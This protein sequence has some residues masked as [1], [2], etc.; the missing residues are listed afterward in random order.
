M[1]Q[2]Y[3][4]GFVILN[5]EVYVGDIVVVVL[6]VNVDGCL[7][8]VINIVVFFSCWM[9]VD[10]IVWLVLFVVNIVCLIFNVVCSIC[11]V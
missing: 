3:V 11:G 1:W 9:F 5:E 6:I 7:F 8:G 10:V 2:V 4:D